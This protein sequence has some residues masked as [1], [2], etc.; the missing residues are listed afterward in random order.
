ML[1]VRCIASVLI[2]RRDRCASCIPE[3]RQGSLSVLCSWICT[4]RRSRSDGE[5]T[6][7]SLRG[8]MCRSVLLRS[9]THGSVGCGG[10]R[11]DG[12]GGE[13]RVLIDEGRAAVIRVQ[14]DDAAC[15]RRD[16]SICRFVVLLRASISIRASRRRLRWPR[17]IHHLGRT[18]HIVISAVWGGCFLPVGGSALR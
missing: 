8:W 13:A 14:A 3:S 1:C 18:V 5:R 16:G 6:T 15:R 12:K 10:R 11:L 7:C 2:R 9:N 4:I 17:R